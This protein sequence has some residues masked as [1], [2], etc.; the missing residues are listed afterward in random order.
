DHAQSDHDGQSCARIARRLP[1]RARRLGGPPR[2]G[3]L[4]AVLLARSRRWRARAH[5]GT[6]QRV[7][8]L[9]R[10]RG[11]RCGAGRGTSRHRNRDPRWRAR[12]VV[13]GAR[14][15][16]RRRHGGDIPPAHADG[17]AR[18]QGRNP[19]TA[20]ARVRAGGRDVPARPDH[21]AGLARAVSV[22]G[23][24]RCPAVRA[25]RPARTR[26]AGRREAL[27]L[28]S[29]VTGATGFVGSAVLR[30][31]VSRGE[32]VRALV[33][34]S[35]DLRLLEGLPVAI[36]RGDLAEPARRKAQLAGCDALFHVAADYRLWVARPEAMYR[37]NVDGTRELLLAA[38]EAGVKRIVYTSSVATLG[39][40]A[41]RLP[42]DET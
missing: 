22:P 42:A 5:D 32:P 13:A 1:L 23:R 20:M 38:A 4:R 29:L 6:H 39:L 35:S 37:T 2:R 15:R 34:P 11:G 16:R 18:R 17:A 30:A 3:L 27:R 25:V 12:N 33:R 9:L 10:S 21:L 8:S 28:T 36:G 31:L 40:R 14:H 7:R 19:A 26:P 41:D 24:H